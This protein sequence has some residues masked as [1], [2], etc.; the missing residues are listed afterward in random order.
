MSVSP[1]SPRLLSAEDDRNLRQRRD[2]EIQHDPGW[3]DPREY[4][5]FSP[6]FPKDQREAAKIKICASARKKAAE[7]GIDVSILVPNCKTE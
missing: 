7:M 6:T 3:K 5:G 2:N 4:P 1:T